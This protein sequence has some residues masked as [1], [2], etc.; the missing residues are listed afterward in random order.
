METDEKTIVRKSGAKLVRMILKVVSNH[1]GFSEQQIC[2]KTRKREIVEARQMA[3]KLTKDNSKLSLAT[4][5]SMI[6]SKD[7]ATVLHACKTIANL[8]ETDKDI[9]SLY[10]KMLSDVESEI[11]PKDYYVCSVCNSRDVSRKAWINANTNEVETI[12]SHELEDSW[13]NKCSSHVYIVLMSEVIKKRDEIIEA[14]K[15][16]LEYEKS[17][18][19]IEEN[20]GI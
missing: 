20:L 12:I 13:C 4:I 5:G 18:K 3:M 14:N 7:H 1:T 19:I 16:K 17:L 9:C 10:E 2:M 15:R 8:L 6:G 11:N